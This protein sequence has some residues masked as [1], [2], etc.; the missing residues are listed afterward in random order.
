[1]YNQAVASANISNDVQKF[2]L[3]SFYIIKIH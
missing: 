1:M 2:K 3:M